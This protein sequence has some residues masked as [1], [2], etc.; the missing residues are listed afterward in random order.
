MGRSI[1]TKQEWEAILNDRF[2]Y[3]SKEEREK[4]LKGD[5]FVKVPPKELQRLCIEVY[6]CLM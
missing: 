6:P 4:L 1:K 5:A 2:S 3:L